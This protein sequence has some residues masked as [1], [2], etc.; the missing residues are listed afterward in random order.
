MGRIGFVENI[1][2]IYKLNYGDIL[3]SNINSVQYIGNTAF[4]DKDYNLYHGMNLLR[5]IP[6]KTIVIPRYLHLLLSTDLLINH[7]QTICNKAVSQASI[8]QTELGKTI[9]YLPSISRQKYLCN[10]FIS[11]ENKLN[12][13]QMILAY[14]RVQKSFLLQ[15]LF[16]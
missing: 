8:N 2:D 16:I 5:L 3:F 11:C 4:I 15:Q 6:N 10:I 14:L 7:F 1:D 9:L 13:E 12:I